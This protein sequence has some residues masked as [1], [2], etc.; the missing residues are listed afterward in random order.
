MRTTIIPV[1]FASLVFTGCAA[2]SSNGPEDEFV[3]SEAK[4]A[5]SAKD[6]YNALVGGYTSKD[7]VYPRF[8]L[9]A[10]RTF[11]LDTGIRC[12]TTPCPSGETGTWTLYVYRG[13][14]YLNLAS[15]T[16]SRWFWVSSFKSATLVNLDDRTVWTKTP[17]VA[18]PGCAAML[19]AAGT[20]CVEEGGKAQCITAC[21]TVKCTSSTYC[22]ASS[23]SAKCVAYKCPT[24]KTIN[25][26]PIVSE[27][28]QKYCSGNYHDWIQANCSTEFVY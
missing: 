18:D 28:N 10:D 12:I 21:A 27:E 19:C 8:T 5:L 20:I 14:Y 2:Q 25:C 22:D 1:L 6:L 17:V 23:G 13:N 26:M 11:D 4:E 16:S 15:K 24:A 3:A 9:N 7:T